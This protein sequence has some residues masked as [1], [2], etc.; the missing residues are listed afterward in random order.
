MEGSDHWRRGPS[1]D[2]DGFCLGSPHSAQAFK[3]RV[4]A[5]GF[6]SISGRPSHAGPFLASQNLSHGGRFKLKLTR[7]SVQSL[8]YWA[9]SGRGRGRTT[10]QLG[11]ESESISV[12]R[13]SPGGLV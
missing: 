11:S 1:Q 12:A 8:N 6:S 13:I 10:R 4:S 7:I 9:S 3:F 2:R 5:G